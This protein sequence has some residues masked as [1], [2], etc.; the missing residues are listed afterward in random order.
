MTNLD[1]WYVLLQ[2]KLMFL[3]LH[4][5]MD[6]L[7]IRKHQRKWMHDHGLLSKF[8]RSYQSFET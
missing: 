5:V 2:L 1:S 7:F 4:V 3:L 8:L 6:T